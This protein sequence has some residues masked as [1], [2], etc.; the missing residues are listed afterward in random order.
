MRYNFSLLTYKVFPGSARAGN[1]TLVGHSITYQFHVSASV[2]VDQTPNEGELSAI[3]VN[4][5]LFVPE[6]GIA[7][8]TLLIVIDHVIVVNACCC[9]FYSQIAGLPTPLG[10]HITE[11]TNASISLMWNYPPPPSEAI[12]H[13]LVT[14]MN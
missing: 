3:T 10:I 7:Y 6:P 5:T 2:I 11:S 1:I 4:T 9:E 13:F 8:T 12:Q 14:S